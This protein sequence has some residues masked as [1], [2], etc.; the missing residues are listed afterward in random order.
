M[1]DTRGTPD[2][3]PKYENNSIFSGVYR[4]LTVEN[5]FQN[6][7]FE[8]TVDMV[9]MPDTINNATKNAGA[10]KPVDNSQSMS[11]AANDAKQATA[12]RMPETASIAIPN[13]RPVNIDSFKP[14]IEAAAAALLAS[15]QDEGLPEPRDETSTFD[16]LDLAEYTIPES[17]PELNIDD[18]V[19]EESTDP[20]SPV[21]RSFFT[22][23]IS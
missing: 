15:R 13:Y 9:R 20:E 22:S 3:N 18:Y 10:G 12:V 16:E 8:Q 5:V 7:K 1:D 14:K 21:P 19:A 17:A 2:K 4:I 6:G 23:T 11:V